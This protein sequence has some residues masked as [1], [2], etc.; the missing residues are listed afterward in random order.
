VSDWQFVLWVA[1]ACFVVG[2]W[3]A[4]KFSKW[5]ERRLGQARSARG[6]RGEQRA[7]RLLIDRGYKVIDQQRRASYPITADGVTKDIGLVL[8]FVVE[9]NGEQLVAEVKTGSAADL[10]RSETR[11][12]L[13]E[14]QLAIGGRCVLLVDPE[15]E[16][17]TEVGF[18]LTRPLNTSSAWPSLLIVAAMAACACWWLLSDH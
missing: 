8:D 5:R 6:K 1:L 18:P 2:A 17:I 13:L 11:R 15:A 4:L 7:E 14:Y 12:Q 3:L 16:T 9:R 10:S